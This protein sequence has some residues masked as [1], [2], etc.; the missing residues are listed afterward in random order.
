M[1]LISRIILITLVDFA[2]ILEALEARATL[3]TLEAASIPEPPDI[4]SLIHIKSRI[5][6][7]LDIRSNQK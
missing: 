5:I 4:N 2:P 1:I 7:K 6:V 3:P